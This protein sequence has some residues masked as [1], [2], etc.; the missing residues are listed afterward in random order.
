M[1]QQRQDQTLV[2]IA[3]TEMWERTNADSMVPKLRL[4]GL[5]MQLGFGVN[6]SGR[7]TVTTLASYVM[8]GRET[9]IVCTKC[10]EIVKSYRLIPCS[11]L[12]DFD[13]SRMQVLEDFL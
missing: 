13:S 10:S 12:S 6:G 2:Q 7:Y 5:R 1:I 8:L 11:H 4:V 9:I 3:T